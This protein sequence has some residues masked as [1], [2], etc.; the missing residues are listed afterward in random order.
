VPSGATLS[1]TTTVRANNQG[2]AFFGD[3]SIALHGT[4]TLL[5]TSKNATSATSHSFTIWDVAQPCTQNKPCTAPFQSNVQ[6]ETESGTSS[7]PGF[8]LLSVGQDTIDCRDGFSHAPEVTT[9]ST[10]T[11]TT[12]SAKTV[13]VTIPKS[14]VQILP[15]PNNGSGN[16]AICYQSDTKF[17]DVNG[18]LT[19]L[20]DLPDCNKVSPANTPPCVVSINKVAGGDLQET[21]LLPPLDPHFW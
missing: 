9:A 7:T 15:I 11:F 14:R 8:L 12:N 20:G 6:S 21:I 10:Q 17:R 19:N 3:L 5:A 2:N 16:Y 13:V 18:N 1:G 4:D